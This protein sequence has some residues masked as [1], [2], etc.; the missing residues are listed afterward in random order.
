MVAISVGQAGFIIFI[1][2]R[3]DVTFTLSIQTDQGPR[4]IQF[5]A[6]DSVIF[7]GA[8]GS[9]KTRLAVHIE[10]S[11]EK[12]GHRIAAHRA[13]VLNIGL[14]KIREQDA[15]HSRHTGVS[16]QNYDWQQRKSY[17]WSNNPATHLLNDFDFIMQA[18]FAERLNIALETYDLVQRGAL[19][20]KG[21]ST[22][23]KKLVEIFGK[24]LP[25]HRKLDITDERVDVAGK[26]GEKYSASEMSD[27]ERTIFYMLGQ[28]LL[29]PQ[30]GVLIVD[31]PELH[32]H[33]SILGKLWDEIQAARPDCGFVFI[34]HDLHFAAHR[35]GQKFVIEHYTHDD[36]N[37][38]W[39]LAP[40]PEDTGFDEALMT[41][42]LGSRLPV[43]FVEGSEKSIDVALYGAC[44][45][46]WTVIPRG[47]CKDVIH[48]VVTMRRN[49]PR[50]RVDCAGIVDADDYTPDEREEF[51]R[52][53]I[54]VLPVSEIESIVLLPDVA[55]TIAAGEGFNVTEINEK[56][57]TLT[58][59]LMKAASKSIDATVMQY[60]FRFIDRNLKKIDL[61]GVATPEQLAIEYKSKTEMLNVE[62]LAQD[63]KK[64]MQDAIDKKDL[65]AVL[66]L[67]DGK[68]AFMAAAAEHLRSNRKD[69]FEAWLIRMF[70]A[71][72]VPGLLDAI[73]KALSEV[74]S[75]I[76]QSRQSV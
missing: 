59:D 9:G 41:L 50:T 45:P 54:G 32:M 42:I 20:E 19:K 31:E 61:S 40:V 21:R 36:A 62:Q 49:A 27:G 11:L 1:G 44:F 23:I 76:K 48:S 24:L 60:C 74:H 67:F 2:R 17:R 26:N 52:Q 22:K 35:L 70:R 12:H 15:L 18:L 57:E 13:L 25:E 39:D 51:K 33:P 46:N 56:I 72:R 64:K 14:Q 38:V 37:P 53:G 68:G 34:T 28:A 4:Q 30:D 58:A 55:K 6:G 73:R 63:I 3:R 75:T 69:R 47:S 29:A 5:E 71:D 7:V 10:K 65:H 8:N 16:R 66:K 43:L